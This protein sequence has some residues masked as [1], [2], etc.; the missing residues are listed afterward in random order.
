MRR[1]L[2]DSGTHWSR[3]KTRVFLNIQQTATAK[4]SF[5]HLKYR[6]TKEE[7][8]LQFIGEKLLFTLLSAHH[9]RNLKSAVYDTNLSASV[10]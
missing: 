7:E 9:A 5:S 2:P 1:I 8:N 6:T 4:K 3:E 10:F